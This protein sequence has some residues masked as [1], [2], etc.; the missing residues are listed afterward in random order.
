[1]HGDGKGIAIRAGSQSAD[2]GAES[3]VV[4]V[5]FGAAVCL[6]EGIE[7]DP[8]RKDHVLCESPL[9]G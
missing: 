3:S 2:G 1:M 7:A 4:G 5:R 9:L 8:R 6:C